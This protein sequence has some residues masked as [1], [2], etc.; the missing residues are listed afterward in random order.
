MLQG[1]GFTGGEA[2]ELSEE[3]TQLA[4][5]FASVF[6]ETSAEAAGRILSGLTGESEPLKK[7]GIVINQAAL[8]QE[9]LRQG[10]TKSVAVMREQEKQMLRAAIIRRTAAQNGF[11]GDAIRTI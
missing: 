7:Y 10:I 6:N 5:D 2:R 8:A 9:A 1:S 11:T 3:L 4:Q